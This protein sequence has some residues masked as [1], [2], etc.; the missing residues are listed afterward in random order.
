MP[1]PGAIPK[2]DRTQVRTRH[3][4]VSDWTEVEDIPFDGA[5]PLRDRATGGISVMAVGVENSQFWPQAT[6]DWWRDISRMPHAAR[7]TD[8]EWRFA[9]D[10]AEI[11]ARTMEGWRGYS[12]PTLTQRE[13]IL[14]TTADF[15]R[16]LRIRYVEPKSKDDD[17]SRTAAAG[18]N[19][20]SLDDYRGL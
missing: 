4:P 8:A 1:V 17:P 15:L 2:T 5:P 18:D 16:G 7:W 10:T 14:G 9:M 3:K 19:V 6:L 11:H 13:K 20:A 12:G